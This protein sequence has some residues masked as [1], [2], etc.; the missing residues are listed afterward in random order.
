MVGSVTQ[1]EGFTWRPVV[2]PS[3]SSLPPAS[4]RPPPRLLWKPVSFPFPVGH[5]P[6]LLRG[7]TGEGGGG[8][9]SRGFSLGSPSPSFRSGKGVWG[10]GGHSGSFG[11]WEQGWQFF[12]L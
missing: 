11:F 4:H 12:S 10:G 9:P 5:S 7:V 8:W 1:W 2:R 6:L 3:G